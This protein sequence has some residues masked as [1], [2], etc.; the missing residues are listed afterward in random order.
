MCVTVSLRQ[1][2]PERVAAEHA[3]LR[4]AVLGEQI[5][6]QRRRPVAQQ[7]QRIVEVVE[8]QHRQDRPEDFL[9][10]HRRVGR[11]VGQNRR[12]E[13]EVARIVLAAVGDLAAAEV[14]GEPIQVFPVDDAAVVRAFLR[15]VAV[16][17]AHRPLQR[18]PP[19]GANAAIHEDEIRRDAGLAGVHE[20]AP[21]DPPRRDVQRRVGANQAR[22]FAAEF[23]RDRREVPGGGRHHGPAHAACCR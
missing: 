8:F 15:V 3:L 10:H 9:L 14:A 17:L 5:Q 7:R 23:E 12:R 18:L 1:T 6:R 22:A 20:L 19:S 11:H 2:P 16:E 21:G 13:V 4:R